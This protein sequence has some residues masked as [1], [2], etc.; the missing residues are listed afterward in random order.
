MNPTHFTE[1]EDMA[2][3]FHVMPIERSLSQTMQMATLHIKR[4][5]VAM[6]VTKAN[7]WRRRIA[8]II[9]NLGTGGGMW[10][11]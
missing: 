5:V 4:E 10:S 7:T 11:A 2:L 6:R 3:N 9:L 8:P 1:P